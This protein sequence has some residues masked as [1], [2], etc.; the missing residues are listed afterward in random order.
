MPSRK[1]KSKLRTASDV[2]A[3]LKWSFDDQFTSQ[4]SIVGYDCRIHGPMEKC[5]DDFAGIDEGGDI[6]EHRIQYFRLKGTKNYDQLLFWDR[7]GRVDR[8]FGSGNQE[9]PVSP[10]TVSNVSKAVATM[11]SI[12]EEKAIRAQEKAKRRAR[13]QARKAAIAKFAEISATTTAPTV[14]IKTSIGVERHVWED[15]KQFFVYD[16]K[17]MDW[18]GRQP[19]SECNSDTNPSNENIK[20]ITWNV[21]FDLTHNEKGE[22]VKGDDTLLVPEDET[23]LRWQELMDVLA[24]EDADVIA[25]QEVTPRFLE[26]IQ[27]CQWVKD[28]YCLSAC[29]EHIQGID[30]YGNLL[31]WKHS[32]FK[33]C[34]GLHLCR[35]GNRNRVVTVSLFEP[36]GNV[37]NISNVHLPADQYDAGDTRDRSHSRQRE[38]GA[39]V[40]KLQALEQIQRNKKLCPIPCL[41]G[42][43]NIG[44][45]EPVLLAPAFWFDAWS[46]PSN[47]TG[48]TDGFTFDWTRNPRAEKTRRHGHSERGPRRID[49]VFIGT[50]NAVIPTRSRLLGDTPKGFP[51]SDHFGV[52]ISFGIQREI[53]SIESILYNPIEVG[54]NA[55][56][57]A[58]VPTTDSLLALVFESQEI[59]S[60][61]LYD[62]LSTLPFAHITLL[63]GFVDLSNIEAQKLAIQAIQDAVHQTLYSKDPSKRWTVPIDQKSLTVFEHRESASL[64][65][66]PK[67]DKGSWLNRLYQTLRASFI[68]CDEQE[69]R[70]ADGWT[71]HCKYG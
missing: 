64:V 68:L 21:L 29:T 65:C 8:L 33:S 41:L 42:D 12:A 45:N 30:V 13:Q 46:H 55:W 7:L 69:S 51:P 54:H 70:F 17:R 10:I 25:L 32:S 24:D 52:S 31:L 57:T 62:P 16:T 34:L 61:K 38:L 19:S 9:D 20:F 14:G 40:S 67:K 4:N 23:S 63:N 49:R 50:Q 28:R 22:L 59:E 6:P 35:D 58:G 36:S 44:P 39:I 53:G 18:I 71:P 48:G 5:V 27:N 60:T 3:R 37:F 43:F 1:S 15:L 26:Q 47:E 11:K 66:A 56:S 2:I